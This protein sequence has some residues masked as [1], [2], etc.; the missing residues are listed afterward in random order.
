MLNIVLSTCL[1]SGADYV[2]SSC[3]NVDVLLVGGFDNHGHPT[4]LGSS[5]FYA[6]CCAKLHNG[7]VLV[8]N[9]MSS[10]LKFGA[11]VSRIC[12]SFQD[13][14]VVVDAEDDRTKLCL[15]VNT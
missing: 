7:G 6:N 13:Q 11:Y 15:P 9:F 3:D 14:V 4:R 5:G 12:D 10:D 2:L 8:V 1:R